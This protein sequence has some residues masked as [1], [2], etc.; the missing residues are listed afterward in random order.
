[1]WFRIEFFF[2]MYFALSNKFSLFLIHGVVK[3]ISF[4][5][6]VILDPFFAKVKSLTKMV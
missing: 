4:Y 1:M 2:L 5:M 3:H 6:D